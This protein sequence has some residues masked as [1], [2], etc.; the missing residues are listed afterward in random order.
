MLQGKVAIVTGASKGIGAGIARHMAAAGAAVVVN[1]A[2]DAAGAARVVRAIEAAGGAAH[3]VRADI[4]GGAEAEPLVEAAM[5]RYGRVDILVNNAGLF[6]FDPLEA[7]TAE[8]FRRQFDV[9]VLGLLLLTKAAV[10]RFPE[11]GGSVINIGSVAAHRRAANTAIYSA[12]K[13]AVDALTQVLAR[14]LGP[15]GIR[16]NA[17]KP[18]AVETEGVHAAGLIGGDYEANLVSQTPLGRYGQPDD[19]APVTVFLAS[20]AARWITGELISVSGGR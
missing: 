3:A 16:V 19:I 11:D 4:A 18:G 14:E 15:R 20:D 9:N 10:A 5:A 8:E 6:R 1:Y 13:S 12:S 17:I 7:I 2:G